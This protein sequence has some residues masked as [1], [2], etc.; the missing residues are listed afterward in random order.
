MTV[1]NDSDVKA[2]LE[3]AIWVSHQLF[4][5]NKVSGLGMAIS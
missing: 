5:R 3:D 1:L 4:A 2:Q